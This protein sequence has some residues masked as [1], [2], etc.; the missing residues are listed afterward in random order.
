MDAPAIVHYEE[1]IDLSRKSLTN[2]F[3]INV[4]KPERFFHHFHVTSIINVGWCAKGTSEWIKKGD[5]LDDPAVPIVATNSVDDYT[6][7]LRLKHYNH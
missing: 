5:Y 2:P 6:S 3:I 4:N 7:D 1:Y